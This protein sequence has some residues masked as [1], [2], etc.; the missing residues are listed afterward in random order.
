MSERLRGKLYFL[1]DSQSQFV[2]RGYLAQKTEEKTLRLQILD[3]RIQAVLAHEFIRLVD[4]DGEQYPFR[5]Q[6]VQHQDDEVTLEVLEIL[7]PKIRYNLR[8]P[9]QNESFI[10]PVSGSWKGRR[11][12]RLLDL[13]CGGV[14]FYSTPGLKQ[15]EVLELVVPV[16]EPPMIL[17]MQVIRTQLF[18]DGRVFYAAKFVD[19]CHDEEMMIRRAVFGVQIQDEQR[20]RRR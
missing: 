8:I 20:N 10:Y 18:H 4:V 16:M 12:V 6:L 1:S 19:L 7:S 15:D 11:A 5:C 9:V 14:A 17:K 13:S 3:N 2:A